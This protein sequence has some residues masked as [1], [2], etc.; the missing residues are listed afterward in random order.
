M[1]FAKRRGAVEVEEDPACVRCERLAGL[2]ES[3]AARSAFEQGDTDLRLEHAQGVRHGRG[4]EVQGV[5]NGADGAAL[6]ELD[7]EPEA[8][9][10]Q[11]VCMEAQHRP[12]L[13]FGRGSGGS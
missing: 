3:D 12:G 2:G 1:N 9:H 11:H 8:L 4:G 13:P 10:A 5:G 7:Q 6:G